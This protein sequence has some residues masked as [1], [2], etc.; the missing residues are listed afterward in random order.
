MKVSVILPTYNEAGKIVNLVAAIKK[1][2]SGSWTREIVVID[3]G[4]QDGRLDLLRDTCG[5]NVGRTDAM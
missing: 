4:N 3:D 5:D 1:Q 2:I